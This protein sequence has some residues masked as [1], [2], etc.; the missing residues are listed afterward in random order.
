MLV[1]EAKKLGSRLGNW[2]RR[3]QGRRLLEAPDKN[4]TTEKEIKPAWLYRGLTAS[5]RIR[6]T[7][8]LTRQLSWIAL[9]HFRAN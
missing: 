9:F 2:L 6:S 1:K 5:S 8:Q 7:Q 3:S 4:H